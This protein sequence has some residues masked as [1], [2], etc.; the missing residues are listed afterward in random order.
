MYV[1]TYAKRPVIL[2]EIVA[3]EGN[4]RIYLGPD[5]QHKLDQGI[6]CN[7]RQ[8]VLKEFHRI[9]GYHWNQ[10]CKIITMHEFNDYGHLLGDVTNTADWQT[11][12][13]EKALEKRTA[14]RA[15][16]DRRSRLY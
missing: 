4:P 8:N 10:R 6:I 7:V 3:I 15:Q 11:Q 1:V 9:F 2:R 14:A 5:E 12:R 13:A 16:A